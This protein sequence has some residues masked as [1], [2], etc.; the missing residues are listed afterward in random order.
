MTSKK[1]ESWLGG[2]GSFSADSNSWRALTS[3]KPYLKRK[4]NY[5]LHTYVQC[6]YRGRGERPPS[7]SESFSKKIEGGTHTIVPLSPSSIS[8]RM[9]NWF[10]KTLANQRHLCSTFILKFMNDFWRSKLWMA[11]PREKT[12]FFQ[13][14]MALLVAY[15][16]TR[17]TREKNMQLESHSGLSKR[18]ISLGLDH[19]IDFDRFSHFTASIKY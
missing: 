13:G 14:Q 10:H 12:A 5:E 8:T 11:D 1:L 4:F 17:F 18:S 16:F 3:I 15:F 6:A 19:F 7:A 9:P 2:R